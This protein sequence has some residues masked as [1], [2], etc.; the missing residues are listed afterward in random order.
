M[1]EGSLANKF[2]QKNI[3]NVTVDPGIHKGYKDF[4]FNLRVYFIP[5]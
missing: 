3:R 1:K 4:F 2:P 5:V